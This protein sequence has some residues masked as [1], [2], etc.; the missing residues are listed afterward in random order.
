MDTFGFVA[1]FPGGQDLLTRT[2]EAWAAAIEG[3]APRLDTPSTISVDTHPASG[4]GW[5]TMTPS[6]PAPAMITVATAAEVVVVAYGDLLGEPDCAGAILRS[7]SAGGVK[8]VRALDGCFGA[9]IV[10]ADG[11]VTLVGDAVGQRTLRFLRRGPLLLVSPHDLVLVASGVKP[12][13]LDHVSVTSIA[14]LG[15]SVGGHSLA[16]HIEV[17]HP[18]TLVRWTAGHIRRATDPLIEPRVDQDRPFDR[19]EHVESLVRT[20]QGA[21]SLVTAPRRAGSKVVTELTAGLD[22]RAV[23]SLLLSCLPAHDVAAVSVGHP[24]DRDVDVAR[25]L[26][27]LYGIS[28]S[29]ITD[30]QSQAPPPADFR[31]HCDLS[32]FAL[33]GDGNAKVFAI[34]PRPIF[35]RWAD[36]YFCGEAGELFRGF[37]YHLLP[38]NASDLTVT[39]AAEALREHARTHATANGLPQDVTDALVTRVDDTCGAYTAAARSPYDVLDLFYVHE[40]FGVW[41]AHCRRRTWEALRWSPFYSRGLARRAFA[42]TPPIGYTSLHRAIIARHTPRALW[43]PVNGRRLPALEMYPRVERTLLRGY[44]GVDR[45]RRRFRY[46]TNRPASAGLEHLRADALAGPLRGYVHDVLLSACSTAGQLLGRSGVDALLERELVAAPVRTAD[47]IGSLL[48]IESWAA[49]ARRAAAAARR[50]GFT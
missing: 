45:V 6:G 34:Q 43:V 28:F 20:A 27:R 40:R 7:W 10:E 48:M 13:E 33:N 23:F 25:R 30:E 17:C 37:Y 50:V 16:R 31:T 41:G 2:V 5:F 29:V 44:A 9:L 49:L 38:A 26:S 11:A 14:S 8:T 39:G 35:E 12:V 15:W 47:R 4:S 32:A 3:L 24:D 1:G 36:T 46:P 19:T 18:M 22:S 42:A 21:V